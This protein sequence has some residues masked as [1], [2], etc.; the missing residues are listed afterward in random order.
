[1]NIHHL[2]ETRAAKIAEIR[3]LG[4]NP[5]QSKF[6]SIESE[7]RSL[8]GQIKNA[9]TIAEFER[10]EAAPADNGMA[11]ELRSY[12]VSKA[13][14]E[15][16]G[17][18]LTGV[19]R[20]VHD[21]LSKGR[22]VRGVMVP[23]SLIF[24]EE[25]RAMLTTG[26]AG[27][28]VATN[29]G[30]LIDRLRPVMAVQS[31]G[32]TIISGLSGNLDLP[33]LVSGPN[34]VWVNEDEP[35]T[36]SDATF[37]KVSLS[38]KTVS[39]EMYLSRRLLLQNGVALENVLR[40]DLAFVLAQALDKAAINGTAAAKQPV[41]ILT[42]IPESATTATDLSDIAADL[43]AA[44]QIDDVTGTT[45]FL[46]NPALM[47]VA[48]KLK[49]GQQRNL[50]TAETFHGER[51]VAT[52]QVPTIAGENPLIFGAFANLLIGYWS[53]V[54][55]LQNPYTDASKGG[56]RLHAF[57]DADVAIRHPEAFAWKAV[58]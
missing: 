45:G 19:E 32:A 34:A 9:A 20:E 17:D 31:L 41:G 1:M 39:G 13:I 24:G 14:R 36:A 57:L 33:R 7:I 53:G 2:K 44:L 11:R 50:S 22:E 58:A 46:T 48:R 18:S 38:P 21:E 43:I 30:G 51:V 27:N 52:N 15:G 16:N 40:Q 3:A 25:N 5:E 49:D 35:T 23:T 6:D 55:I 42:Q 4:A 56:L 28:T 26:T 8:D 29:M 47:A 12:S 10:H 54:D 37:D